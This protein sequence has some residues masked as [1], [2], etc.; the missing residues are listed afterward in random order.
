[1]Q[2]KENF[3]ESTD[4]WSVANI[5]LAILYPLG[6]SFSCTL[7]QFRS[8]VYFISSCYVV[9]VCRCYFPLDYPYGQSAVLLLK[10][11]ATYQASSTVGFLF[12]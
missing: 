11:R 8:H 1:M 2:T 10:F 9:V 6:T 3:Y 4:V 7:Y 12:V 5:S